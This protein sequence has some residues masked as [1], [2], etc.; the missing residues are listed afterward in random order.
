MLF[1]CYISSKLLRKIAQVLLC[2]PNKLSES[3]TSSHQTLRFCLILFRYS[4]NKKLVQKAL[5]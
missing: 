3:I 2:S 4:T 5:F 1:H